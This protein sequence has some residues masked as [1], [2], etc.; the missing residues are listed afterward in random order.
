MTPIDAFPYSFSL[1]VKIVLEDSY[2]T[3]FFFNVVDSVLKLQK[4][5]INYGVNDEKKH[6]AVVVFRV[7][8]RFFFKTH[9]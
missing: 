3:F 9:F 6:V 5:Q 4:Q 2:L 1:S 7:P 8:V